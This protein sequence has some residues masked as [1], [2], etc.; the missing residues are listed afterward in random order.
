MDFKGSV[1]PM[2]KPTKIKF[3]WVSYVLKDSNIFY[4]SLAISLKITA[5]D[6]S[7]SIVAVIS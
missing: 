5:L 4:I 1:L 7:S 3:S 6:V 2:V